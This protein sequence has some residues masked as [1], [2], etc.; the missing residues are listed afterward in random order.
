M[1]HIL[2]KHFALMPSNRRLAATGSRAVWRPYVRQG[3]DD[4]GVI[5]ADLVLDS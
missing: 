3:G 1:L 2:R 5:N 4:A